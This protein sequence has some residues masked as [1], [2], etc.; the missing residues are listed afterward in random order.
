[1][2]L[3]QILLNCALFL[4]CFKP[5]LYVIRSHGK[6][7]IDPK[8]L[9]SLSKLGEFESNTFRPVTHVKK[10]LSMKPESI[11]PFQFDIKKKEPKSRRV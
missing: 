2:E 8:P 3:K 10:V 11:L 1:M 5:N 9:Y 6:S 7:T 4:Q